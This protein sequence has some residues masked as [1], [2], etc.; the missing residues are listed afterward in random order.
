[1]CAAL[2]ATLGSCGLYTRYERP[3]LEYEVSGIS[4]SDSTVSPIA[5]MPW[6]EVFTDSCLQ[7]WIG[8][9]LERNTDLRIAML[10]AE[11]AAATLVP[12]GRTRPRC[13]RRGPTV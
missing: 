13:F 5:A 10:R 9:G 7:S 1:M 12:D 11:E 4:R 6:S 3:A 8:R 2:A